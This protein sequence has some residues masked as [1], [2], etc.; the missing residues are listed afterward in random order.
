MKGEF[1]VTNQLSLEIILGLDFLE[2][3][4]CAINADQR[5][6]HLQGKALSLQGGL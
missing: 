4:H 5:T 1:L 3:N 6:L 2:Q